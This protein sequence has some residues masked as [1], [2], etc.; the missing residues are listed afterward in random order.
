MAA[1]K[2]S[3]FISSS[4]IQFLM[5]LNELFILEGKFSIL[6]FKLDSLNP[7]TSL[8]EVKPGV[9]L[10]YFSSDSSFDSS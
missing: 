1:S 4:L 7:E 6:N 8:C 9:V 3:R 2:D 5:C 10:D